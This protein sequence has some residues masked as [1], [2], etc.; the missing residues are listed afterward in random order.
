M[1]K[2][3]WFKISEVADL[4]G[5]SRRTIERWVRRGEFGDVVHLSERS[6]RIPA[7]NVDAFIERKRRA[8]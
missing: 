6:V 2:R 5:Y 3:K 4:L 7:E 1:T 8:A